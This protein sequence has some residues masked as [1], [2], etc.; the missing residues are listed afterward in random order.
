MGV[1]VAIKG[2]CQVVEYCILVLFVSSFLGFIY[3]DY[4]P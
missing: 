3:V 1:A 4:E 2:I